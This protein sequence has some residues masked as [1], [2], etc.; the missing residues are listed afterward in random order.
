MQGQT[1]IKDLIGIEDIKLGFYQEARA[2]MEEL[3]CKNRELEQKQQEIQAILDGIVDVM[4]V[5]SEELEVISVN[6]VYHKF[7]SDSWPEGKYCFQ[8]LKGAQRPCS[9]CPA[10]QALQKDEVQRSSGT[11]Y[12]AGQ[13][14]FF[15]LLA[16]PL[17]N[18]GDMQNRVL[19]FMRDVTLEKE[20]QTQFLQAE[21]MATIGLLAAGVAHE[22]NNP[23]TS[24]LGF[25]QGLQRRLPRVREHLEQELAADMQEYVEII[26]NECQRCQDIVQTLLSFSRSNSS[27]SQVLDLNT[28]L[29]ECLKI[30]RYK[31]KNCP[32]VSLELDL[33]EDLDGISGDQAQLKQVVLNL[34]TN[35]ID[36]VEPAGCI[37]VSTSQDQE[38]SVTLMVR[39][40]GPGIPRDHLDRVF[41]PFFTT[42]PQGK[43]TGIGLST[44]YNIVSN[45]QGNIFIC[46]EEGYGTKVYVRI[47]GQDKGVE[48]A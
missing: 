35:A 20:Y 36:A 13:N 12:C 25:T 44:C 16:S 8:A 33:Q 5:L 29:R 7:F 14:R 30:L 22:I 42:K 27:L 19:L 32:E 28:M 6:R 17:Q 24:I 18:S 40:N 38:G 1:T 23:L 41:D 3:R 43:G 47:P 9:S 31:L 39:D 46:S 11:Y 10:R 21:K 4:I 26:L 15:D 34:L 2:K 45:H 48:N 37:Q